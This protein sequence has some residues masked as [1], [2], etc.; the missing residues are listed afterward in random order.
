MVN[1]VE[2]WNQVTP[3]LQNGEELL[4]V[5]KPMP[6]RVVLANGELISGLV[7]VVVLLIVLF[8]FSSFRM[9]T[10]SSPAGSSSFGSPFSIF[11]W[12]PLIFVAIG[13]FTL[14][15]PLYEFV[16]AA[17]TIYGLTD[18]RAL[19][20]KHGFSGKSVESYTEMDQL[21]RTSIANGKGDLVFARESTR[22]RRKGGYRTRTRKIGFFG[23]D[24]VREVEAL[25]LRS[26]T[27]RASA[28]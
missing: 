12:F 4:W 3:E 26:L 21:E 10:F 17:R 8:M 24:N 27:I 9:P 5:G 11:S 20:I 15:K 13:L 2:L 23:I 22:Y 19:I 16:M 7:G 28:I 18:H 6:L 14:G 1:D 25:M